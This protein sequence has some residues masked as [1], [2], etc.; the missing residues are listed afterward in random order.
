MFKNIYLKDWMRWIMKINLTFPAIDH[1]I[2][3]LGNKDK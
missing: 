3:K 1:S 2:K